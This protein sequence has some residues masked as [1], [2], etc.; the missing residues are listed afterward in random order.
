MDA[1][2]HCRIAGAQVALPVPRGAVAPS[3]AAERRGRRRRP[4][5]RRADTTGT[6]RACGE[7]VGAA[8]QLPGV[9]MQRPDN[10]RWSARNRRLQ[11]REGEF[12][13]PEGARQRVAGQPGD[14]LRAAEQQTGLGSAQQFVA[15][16]GDD[17]GPVRPTRWRR[18]VLRAGSGSGASSPL[19]RSATS[20]TPCAAVSGLSSR[21][22]TAEV[23]PSTR[24]L[25]GWTF[26]TQPVSGPRASA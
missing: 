22:G 26:S 8:P 6:P 13:G 7:R 5:G 1:R 14:D 4:L 17:V 3:P 21:N 18:P 10:R 2:Q 16:G 19:P 24:K 20:A 11:R 25:L 9:R 15:A 23:N 12:V